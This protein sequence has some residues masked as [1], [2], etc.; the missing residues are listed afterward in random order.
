MSE[1]SSSMDKESRKNQ[2]GGLNEKA[3]KVTNAKIL[4]LTLKHLAKSWKPRRASLRSNEGHE[5]EVN[6]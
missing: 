4:D 2:S 6:F 1:K 5:K 3:E